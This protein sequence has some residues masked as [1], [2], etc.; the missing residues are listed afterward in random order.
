MY[1][2]LCLWV[3]K[4]FSSHREGKG[5][6]CEAKGKEPQDLEDIDVESA[7]LTYYPLSKQCGEILSCLERLLR[8][9]THI[10]CIVVVQ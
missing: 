1:P 4:A 7:F 2:F 3:R 10:F 8:I 9:L 6:M 5:L